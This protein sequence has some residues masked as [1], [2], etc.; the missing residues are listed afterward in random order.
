MKEFNPTLNLSVNL[1]REGGLWFTPKTNLMN[2][3]IS[4]CSA[5]QHAGALKHVHVIKAC[6]LGVIRIS[7]FSP[8]A[9]V[10]LFD[11]KNEA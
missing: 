8:F 1:G 7:D 6:F 11:R 3:N 10:T 4:Y 2:L 5:C 9:S